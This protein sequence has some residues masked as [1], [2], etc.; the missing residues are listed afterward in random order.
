MFKFAHFSI[1]RWMDVVPRGY[2]A[3]Q[4]FGHAPQAGIP[5]EIQSQGMLRQVY[6]MDLA[7]FIAAERTATKVA[8]G[9]TRL[10]DDEAT[11]LFMAS[12]TLDEARHFEAF[13]T[14]FE[15][16]GL[17]PSSRDRL[18]RD[19]I[20][21]AYQDFLDLILAESVTPNLES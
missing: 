1:D 2:L 18:A 7:L 6:L 10:A 8:A 17:P 15:D 11:M 14:R 21:P 9:L 4:S 13:S 12:Q 19:Y 3:E 20:S 16:L 5:E